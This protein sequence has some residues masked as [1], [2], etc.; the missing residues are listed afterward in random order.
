MLFLHLLKNIT[1]NSTLCHIDTYSL[2][3]SKTDFLPS[4]VKNFNICIDLYGYHH[5]QDAEQ[6][7]HPQN[8]ILSLHSHMF[9]PPTYNCWKSLISFASL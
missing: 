8:F 7:H 9:A 5:N 1:V 2:L 3:Y 6:F 4:Y